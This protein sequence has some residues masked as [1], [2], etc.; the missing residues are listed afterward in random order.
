MWRHMVQG[1][2][3]WGR[4]A[5]VW[6]PIQIQIIIITSKFPRNSRG[7]RLSAWPTTAVARVGDFFL[8]LYISPVVS[9]TTSNKKFQKYVTGL[10]TGIFFGKWAWPTTSVA[11]VGE[12]FLIL[13][14][15]PVVSAITSN[16]KF[17]KIR[18]RAPYS[19]FCSENGRGRPRPSRKSENFFWF[20]MHHQWSQLPP[21]T[22]NFK[23]YVTVLCTADYRRQTDRRQTDGQKDTRT[24]WNY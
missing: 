12:F 8:I 20:Y 14:I 21:P 13:Y 18:F 19:L 9:A 4:Y 1:G 6:H 2:G 15:S 17:Q 24:L 23:K 10:R 11:R 5:T 22:K 16:K 7:L 3:T